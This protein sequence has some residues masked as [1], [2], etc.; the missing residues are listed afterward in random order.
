MVFVKIVLIVALSAVMAPKPASPVTVNV[1]PTVTLPV[2]SESPVTFKVA[3]EVLSRVVSPT[4]SNVPTIDVAVLET[5]RLLAKLDAPV[6]FKVV[7]EVLSKVAR[8]V[9]FNAPP[10]V[11]LS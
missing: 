3:I 6:T 4:T 1:P 9:V 7:I 2:S 11:A 8:P 10:I 5:N